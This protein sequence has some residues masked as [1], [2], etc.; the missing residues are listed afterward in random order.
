M[1]RDYRRPA[2]GAQAHKLGQIPDAAGEEHPPVYTRAIFRVSAYGLRQYLRRLSPSSLS[3]MSVC[4][5]A[6][7][8]RPK[9]SLCGPA[10]YKH[11]L[12]HICTYT[13]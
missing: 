8:L 5:A 11:V 2:A 4:G 6:V 3:N 13:G 12:T 10:L 9:P 1:T 7:L